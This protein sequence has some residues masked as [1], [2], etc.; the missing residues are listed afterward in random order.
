MLL[1]ALVEPGH[2]EL[3]AGA[4]PDSEGDG[5]VDPFRNNNLPPENILELDLSMQSLLGDVTMT[6]SS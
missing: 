4:Q 2:D 5:G 6:V 1:P 3:G